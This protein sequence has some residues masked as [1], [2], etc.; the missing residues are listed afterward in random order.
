MDEELQKRLFGMLAEMRDDLKLIKGALSLASTLSQPTLSFLDLLSAT[1]I[2]GS[3]DFDGVNWYPGGA[4]AGPACWAGPGLLSAIY[5]PLNRDQSLEARLWISE[6]HPQV[7]QDVSIFIDGERAGDVRQVGKL[8]HIFRIPPS[9]G[10][11]HM[12][13]LSFL[14]HSTHQRHFETPKGQ[15]ERWVSFAFDKLEVYPSPGG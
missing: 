6:F 15:E 3:D 1:V 4:E 10:R 5:L 2:R 7:P 12:T 8:D 13:E 14:T 11:L 9:P